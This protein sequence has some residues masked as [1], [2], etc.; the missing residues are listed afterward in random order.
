M[1][2][3]LHCSTKI[4]KNSLLS[5]VKSLRSQSNLIHSSFRHFATLD[6]PLPLNK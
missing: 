2:E 3:K 4:H 1:I 5:P 6:Y